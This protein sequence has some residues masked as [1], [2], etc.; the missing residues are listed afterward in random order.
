LTTDKPVYRSGEPI[1]L[2]LKLVNPSRQE[3]TLEFSSSQRYDFQIS[4]RAGT[5]V[6][7]WS[8]G[9]MFAQML[10]SERLAPGATREYRE[11]FEG[12]LPAGTYVA[13]GTIPTRDTPLRAT[14]II[15]IQ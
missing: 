13:T 3:R 15:A 4:D 2:I 6:W 5:T 7:H 14:T 12:R 8:A 9:R 11:R 10:G 1:E